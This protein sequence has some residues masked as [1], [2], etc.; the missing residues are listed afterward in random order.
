MAHFTVSQAARQL[1]QKLGRT[2]AP[3]TISNLF[4]RRQLDD[5]RC[6]VV[7]RIRLIPSDYLSTIELAL[8]RQQTAVRTE[9]N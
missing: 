9:E 4:Y 8:Q 3:Q 1:S 6:P 2:V 7:G 5:N